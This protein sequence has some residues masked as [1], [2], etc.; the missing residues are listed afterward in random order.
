MGQE[1]RDGGIGKKQVF[2]HYFV[3]TRSDKGQITY[4]RTCGTE[5]AARARVE[6]LEA[7]G[8]KAFWQTD[9]KGGAFY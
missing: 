2:E 9:I 1:R 5:S 8:I 6:E 3:Y 4:E 7:R